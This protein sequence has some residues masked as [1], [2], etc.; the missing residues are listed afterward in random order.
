MKVSELFGLFEAQPIPKL[1]DLWKYGDDFSPE[2]NERA[3]QKAMA[4]IER[5]KAANKAGRGDGLKRNKEFAAQSFSDFGFPASYGKDYYDDMFEYLKKDPKDAADYV[6]NPDTL[7]RENIAAEMAK[8]FRAEGD[9]DRFGAYEFFLNAGTKL[10]KKYAKAHGALEDYL[11]KV[12]GLTPK[13]KKAA[14]DALEADMIKA[15]KAALKA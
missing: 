13:P 1:S 14:L 7:T 8:K 12:R 3:R 10:E 6:K 15:Y 9:G 5:I 4:E 11:R 2:V